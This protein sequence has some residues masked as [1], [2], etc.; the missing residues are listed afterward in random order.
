MPIRS[1]RKIIQV[2]VE[3]SYG[4][5][6]APVVGTDDMLVREFN[7]SSNI[8]YVE[9]NNAL[10]FFGH[11]GQIKVGDT[12]KMEFDIELAGS[13]AV[14]AK[15]GYS[16]ILRGCGMSETL[17]PTTGP[18]IYALITTGEESVT[19]YFN[20]DGQLHKIL[21][22]YGTMELRFNE[23]QVPVAHITLEGLY[24]GISAVAFGTPVLSAFQKPLAM[25]K[26]NTTFNL[27]GYAAVLL[28]LTINQGNQIEYINRP[29]SERMQFADRKSTGKVSIELPTV[30]AKDFESICR[31]ETTGALAI[32]HGISAGNKV[33]I[34]AGQVQ[35]INPT[36]SENPNTAILNMDMVL[37]P[38]LAGNNEWTFKT[39]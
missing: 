25:N 6:A 35:L 7:I 19:S 14:A 32:V 27:H 34:D 1:K 5:D 33:L 31:S 16:A 38:T 30:A 9:R 29:N 10:P 26:Q 17:T 18:T 23:G 4:V 12:M 3:S 28:S 20:W 37:Q 36:K 13:G 39:Q 8:R 24:G 2:K 11:Q 15:P 21:G 22:A